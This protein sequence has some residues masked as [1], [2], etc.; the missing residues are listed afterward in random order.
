MKIR[1]LRFF[2]ILL[3]STPP[4]ANAY[5]GNAAIRAGEELDRLLTAVPD[6]YQVTNMVDLTQTPVAPANGAASLIRSKSRLQGRVMLADLIPGHAY[7][8]W[9][10]IFNKP[11]MCAATPCAPGPDF[12]PARAAV[13]FA[14]SGI[15]ASGGGVGGEGG[16]LNVTVDTQ[17]GGPPNGAFETGAGPEIG[18][19][20]DNG[21][22]AE[23]HFLMIDHGVPN[24]S[25]ANVPGSWAWELST[26]LPPGVADVRA[27]LFPPTSP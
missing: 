17:A 22:A 26:P 14:G 21:F 9:W 20:P 19:T 5:D 15:A 1:L 25:F 23:V 4:L 8:V 11:K 2:S 3:M 7:T 18:L 24:A 27:A 12:G 10:L 6:T 13:F 16:V